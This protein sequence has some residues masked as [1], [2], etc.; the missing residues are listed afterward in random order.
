MNMPSMPNLSSLPDLLAGKIPDEVKTTTVTQ[1]HVLIVSHA[2][3]V[4][5][6]QGHL[7]AGFSLDTIKIA[8]E[9]RAILQMVCCFN[10]NFHYTP[11][12]IPR[13]DFWQMTLRVLTRQ[14]RAA[15]PP[16]AAVEQ[17]A[18]TTTTP[19]A[20]TR[21][22]GAYVFRTFLGTRAAWVLQR[23]V[24]SQ[25]EYA[26]FNVITRGAVERGEY[27][28]FVA[29]IVPGDETPPTQ[30]AVRSLDARVAQPP[31]VSWEKMAHFL[32]HRPVSFQK[33]SVGDGIVAMTAEH[34]DCNPVMGEFVPVGGEVREARF[35]VWEK[36][37]VMNGAEMRS[38]F[39]ILIQPEIVVTAQAPR[40][41]KSG[42]A[43]A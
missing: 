35:G 41:A 17:P 16:P 29:D 25:S 21:E 36:M 34:P 31:F 4:S 13:L 15:T 12:P 2:V 8:G 3:P 20:S 9:A 40:L 43:T 1:R 33:L 23:A 11:L 39:S 14:P 28:P 24:A 22:P 19:P 18:T 37:G 6:L 30:I 27:A 10:D 7:P 32:T 38:P 26:D 42:Q 5:R